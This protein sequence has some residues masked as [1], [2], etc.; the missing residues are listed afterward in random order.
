[1]RGVASITAPF[2][3]DAQ[4]TLPEVSRYPVIIY[5]T[6][7]IRTRGLEAS[8]ILTNSRKPEHENC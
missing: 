6:K 4:R 2:G 1:M 8:A 7:Y 5:S 3:G